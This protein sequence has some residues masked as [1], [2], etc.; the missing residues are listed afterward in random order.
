MNYLKLVVRLKKIIALEVFVFTAF[1][2]VCA[3]LNTIIVKLPTPSNTALAVISGIGKVLVGLVFIGI[4]LFLWYYLTNKLMK[5]SRKY[6]N[7]NN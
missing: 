3:I 4:W 5:T 2:A 7:S 1:L 6:S